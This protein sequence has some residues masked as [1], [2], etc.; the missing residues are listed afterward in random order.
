MMVLPLERQPYVSWMKF[1]TVK[2]RHETGKPGS[3]A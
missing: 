1:G 2:P 3:T